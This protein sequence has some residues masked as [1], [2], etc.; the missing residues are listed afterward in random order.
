[1]EIYSATMGS[2]VEDSY[3]SKANGAALLC[4]MFSCSVNGLGKL[5]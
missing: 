4:K 3:E 1:M 2:T 5:P